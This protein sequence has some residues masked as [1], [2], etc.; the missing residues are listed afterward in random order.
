MSSFI[1]SRM[2]YLQPFLVLCKE[3]FYTACISYPW[4][5]KVLS[6]K[7]IDPRVI[8]PRV[9]G[10]ISGKNATE[11]PTF[12]FHVCLEVRWW[13]ELIYLM[14]TEKESPLWRLNHW[15]VGRYNVLIRSAYFRAACMFSPHRGL[16]SHRT[17]SKR[18]PQCLMT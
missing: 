18:K 11:M 17:E 8:S 13:L 12:W 10:L 9:C 2:E 1:S 3:L 16:A 5:N 6:L 7:Y 4:P 15:V 14:V